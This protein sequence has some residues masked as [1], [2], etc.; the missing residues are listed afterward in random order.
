M[1]AFIVLRVEDEKENFEKCISIRKVDGETRHV[2]G[3]CNQVPHHRDKVAHKETQA[4]KRKRESRES[5]LWLKGVKPLPANW[6]LVD[7]CDQ[8]AEG[9]KRQARQH[10]AEGLGGARLGSRST[11]R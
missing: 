10:A 7:V 2:L 3:L 5:L 11:R 1:A 4:R 8:G 9:K 6:S